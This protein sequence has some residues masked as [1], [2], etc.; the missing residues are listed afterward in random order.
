MNKELLQSLA[1]GNVL[2][3][4]TGTPKGSRAQ[5][6]AG[7]ERAWPVFIAEMALNPG[8][9]G[10][11]AFWTVE[12]GEVSIVGVWEDM[13]KRLAYERNSS[14]TVRAIFN[15]LLEQPAKRHKQVTAKFHWE[16]SA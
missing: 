16:P 4:V 15:A 14:E 9:K 13:D 12:T 2:G 1:P 11:G 10:A 7:I 8:F 3:W 6:D 5:W